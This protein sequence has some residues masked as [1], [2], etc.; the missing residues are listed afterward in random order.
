MARCLGENPPYGCAHHLEHVAAAKKAWQTRRAGVS[1]AGT[2]QHK[3]LSALFG[4]EIS[5]AHD[6]PEHKGMMRFKHGGKWYELP[7]AEF[8]RLVHE[9]EQLQREQER[10][11]K[12]A[13][14]NTA[15]AQKE[16]E[17][18][19]LA[20]QRIMAQQE[21]QLAAAHKAEYHSVVKRIRQ[22]G[23][24]RPNRPDARGK[25]PEASEWKALP[26]SV[27][28][29]CKDCGQP[30][31]E[32]AATISEE[33]PWLRINNDTELRNFLGD[34]KNQ[35]G[36]IAASWFQPPAP[37]PEQ[38]K[39]VVTQTSGGKWIINRL[40][41]DGHVAGQPGTYASKAAAEKAAAGMKHG[42]VVKPA[43]FGEREDTY[44]SDLFAQ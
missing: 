6:A 32:M 26:K 21:R 2:R 23:G 17:R 11:Q 27:K 3:A 44:G 29:N 36:P 40:Y 13:E 15:K 5:H 28:T 1:F 19:R 31:D 8:N 9:G 25:I 41:S 7:K 12:A 14:R 30:V 4:E 33:F 22:I 38:P 24:I 37:K 35:T 10:E 34:K 16:E 20:E 18:A 39:V 42:V 43:M